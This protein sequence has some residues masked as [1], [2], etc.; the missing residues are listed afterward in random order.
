[1]A[2]A[3]LSVKDRFHTT[4]WRRSG[5]SDPVAIRIGVDLQKVTMVEESGEVVDVASSGIDRAA[6]IEAV[7]KPNQVW[8]SDHYFA[9]LM[10]A[11]RMS[12]PS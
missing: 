2:E 12:S 4:N 8:C 11:A 5:F 7:V 10:P 9:Q 3:A 1:M 6:R